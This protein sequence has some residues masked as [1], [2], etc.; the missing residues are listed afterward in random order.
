MT[1]GRISG[2]LRERV[3]AQAKYRCGY[4]LTTEAIVG[5]P[6]EIDH[7]IPRS[8]G[9]PD[10]EDNLWLAC[11]LCNTY[12]GDR[13]AA[14]DPASGA[15]TPLFNP[16]MMVWGEHFTWTED[17]ERIVGMTVCGRATVV[18]LYLNRPSL[19]V[20]RRAWVSVGWHPPAE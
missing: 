5:S 15:L 9:G 7:L 2:H 3:A 11:S 17:G 4:C 13:M 8:L 6:M 18:A 16:R 19:V 1:A 20:A 10:A 14:E 12:K